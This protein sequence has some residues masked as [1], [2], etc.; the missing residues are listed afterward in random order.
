[1]NAIEAEVRAMTAQVEVRFTPHNAVL[2][3]QAL[4]CVLSLL[5]LSNVA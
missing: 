4:G 1:V 2:L 3:S 5:H